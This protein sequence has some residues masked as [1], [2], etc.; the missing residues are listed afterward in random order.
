MRSTSGAR[1]S[2]SSYVGTMTASSGGSP[3]AFIARAAILHRRPCGRPCAVPRRG[4]S[5]AS[6]AAG[7]EVARAS[8]GVFWA[9]LGLFA[10]T[11]AR[12]RRASR[13]GSHTPSREARAL[14]RSVGWSGA[15]AHSLTGGAVSG[16]SPL[17]R[18]WPA[19]VHAPSR[20]ARCPASA[21]WGIV[22]RRGCTL[23]R[24]RR[25]VRPQPVGA[26]LAGASARSLAGGAVSGLSPLGHCWP[27]RVHAPSREARCPASARWGIVGRLGC[28]LPCG[29]R[30][31]RPQPVGACWPARMHTP[32]REARCPASAR[33]GVVGRRGCTLPYGRRGVRPPAPRE[34]V[35]GRRGCTLPRGRR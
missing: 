8:R 33:R 1:L 35:A 19:R 25:G 6:A 23:P 24:G 26:L 34:G 28:T 16:L 14:T 3:L 27:A 29:R 31:V 2:R 20:E 7:R 12:P 22:G 9:Q 10:R 15:G 18:R 5:T 13:R 17:G 21:R 11:P 4:L 32:L 30:G